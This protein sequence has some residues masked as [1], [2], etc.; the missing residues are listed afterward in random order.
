MTD[1]TPAAAP[2]YASSAA[3]AA[4]RRRRY[5]ADRRLRYYGVGA[6][7]LALG[8][9]GIL[10]T[11]LV[12]GG[13][14]AFTQTKVRVTFPISADARRSGESRRGQLPEDRPGGPRR[15]PAR[16]AQPEGAPR[17]RRHP[18]RQHPVHGS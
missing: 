9:L 4:I 6:I 14:P 7:A 16:R 15:A 3:A 10:I 17:T 18:H 13:Y 11:T 12:I 8:L 5:A 1:T 2:H